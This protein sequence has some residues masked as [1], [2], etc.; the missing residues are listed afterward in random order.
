MNAKI[1]PAYPATAKVEPA[2]R[3]FTLK[4]WGCRTMFANVNKPRPAKD[5]KPATYDCE[6]LLPKTAA[7]AAEAIKA[8]R[9]FGAQTYNKTAWKAVVVR[10]GDKEIQDILDMGGEVDEVRGLKRGHWVIRANAKADYPPSVSGVIYSGCYAGAVIGLA[11][12]EAPDKSSRGIKGY[13]NGVQFQGDGEALSGSGATNVESELGVPTP[14][15]SNLPE[16]P[17]ED[18]FTAGLPG[19]GANHDRD[20]SLPFG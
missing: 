19:F 13:L 3:G 8:I 15:S 17:G 14:A 7:G 10:D 5:G 1:G 11:P 12:Y 9:D 16:L 2:R 20:D 18:D 4:L 6:F